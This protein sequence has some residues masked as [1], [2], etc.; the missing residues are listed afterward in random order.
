[1]DRD[2]APPRRRRLGGHGML[3]RRRRIFAWLRDGMTYDE[4]AAR[5]GC[6]RPTVARAIGHGHRS[7]GLPEPAGRHSRKGSDGGRP[8]P[9]DPEDCGRDAHPAA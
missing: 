5:L 8:R 6:C 7:R 4:I 3:L 1:M 2:M 9:D